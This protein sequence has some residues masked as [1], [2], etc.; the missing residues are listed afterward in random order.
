MYAESFN[1]LVKEI[2]KEENIEVEEMSYGYMLKL[3]KNNREHY[4]I[5]YRFELNNQVSAAIAKD[6][7]ATYEI[8]KK[9]NIPV[10]EYKIL[11]NEES[12]EKYCRKG[13]VEIAT[14][15]FYKNNEHIVI[16]P[17]TGHEGIG[18]YFCDKKEKIKPILNEVYKQNN[19]IVLCPYYNIKTEYRTIY[20]NGQCMITY[21]KNIPYLIGDGKLNIKELIKKEQN[22]E[23]ED[24]RKENL[25]D[26]DFN[27][28]P[29]ENEKVEIFWK[30]NLS[31]GANPEILEE[32]ELKTKIQNIVRQT[33]EA[34]N[35]NF[36]SI[37][38]IETMQGELYL[39]E[40]NSGI[41]MKNFIEKHPEGK[42]IAKEIYSK[43]IKEILKK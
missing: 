31:G 32:G 43:A 38:V 7:Y 39:L 4:I 26:V 5:G 34:I 27:Y 14:E 42:K 30:H 18:V 22:L 24:I 21:G 1:R 29:K 25:K 20:L 35:I 28:I 12:R 13:S 8:L 2:C 11:F 37:D 6:K 40:V 3:K 9:N 16:K 19:S 17:N 23:L 10:V 36:A 15:Y 33:A 41:F